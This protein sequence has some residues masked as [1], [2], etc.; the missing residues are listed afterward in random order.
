M[1][2]YNQDVSHIG[3]LLKVNVKSKD[4][5]GYAEKAKNQKEKVAVVSIDEFLIE[6]KIEKIDIL[7][8]DVQGY[9]EKVLK[10]SKKFLQLEIQKS[11][12]SL[13]CIFC[14]FITSMLVF[15]K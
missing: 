12:Q 6:H 11:F 3:S 13:S 7:K 10:G 2:Y 8:I 5:I 4:S 14:L 9:E 15:L 1:D